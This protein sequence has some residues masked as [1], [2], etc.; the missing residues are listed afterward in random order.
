[1]SA[2]RRTGESIESLAARAGFEIEWEDAH[3]VMQRVPESTLAALL[4]R[5]GLPCGN[6]GELR[7]SAAALDAEL[8]GR[9]LPPLMTAECGRGIALPAAAIKSGSRY[10][11]ELE[12]G[13]ADRRPLHPRPKA[14]P[15]CCRRSKSLAIT[16]SSSTT[17]G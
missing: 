6:A 4:A 13:R 2:A 7:H 10:R 3:R 17:T 16:R 5:M 11:I 1:M 14:K 9:K 12:S 15:R 8:S